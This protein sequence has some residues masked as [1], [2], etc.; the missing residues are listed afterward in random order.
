[1]QRLDD[2]YSTIQVFSE[3]RSELMLSN[4][5]LCLICALPLTSGVSGCECKL[6]FRSGYLHQN[7][8]GPSSVCVATWS[9]LSY[10]DNGVNPAD[11]I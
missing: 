10:G 11:V 5:L 7:E 3:S 4:L 2:N 1:M 8:N 9:P 6:I